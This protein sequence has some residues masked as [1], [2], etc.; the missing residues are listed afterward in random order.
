MVLKTLPDCGPLRFRDRSE[1]LQTSAIC[2]YRGDHMPG[3][4]LVQRLFLLRF[5]PHCLS[6]DLFLH[7]VAFSLLRI[8]ILDIRDGRPQGS[9]S[10]H[11]GE[12]Y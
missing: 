6:L 5:H 8:D 11:P 2:A 9:T 1:G 7:C 3:S 4:L 10:G 12:R